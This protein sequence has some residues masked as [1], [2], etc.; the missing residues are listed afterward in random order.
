MEDVVAVTYAGSLFDAA[1]EAQCEGELLG[2]LK[3]LE[4]ILHDTPEFLQLLGVPNMLKTQKFELIDEAF[5]GKAHPY[6]VHFLKLLVDMGRTS[7]LYAIV[8][9]YRRLYRCKYRI[10][11]AQVTT[12]VE[13]TD[14]LK[15]KLV[16]KLQEMTGMTVELEPVVDPNILGGLVVQFENERFD[17][18]VR[19]R[20]DTL[21]QTLIAS[22]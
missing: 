18:S 19:T 3:D 16:Q 22:V 11:R 5:E 10:A 14:A 15:D 13:L 1:C 8:R 12:A 9:E 20:L 6:L 4:Q 21:R 2:Q 7:C 17:A